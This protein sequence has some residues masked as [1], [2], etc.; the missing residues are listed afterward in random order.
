MVKTGTNFLNY[1][2][3]TQQLAGVVV[4]QPHQ[5]TTYHLGSREWPS[6]QTRF[7]RHPLQ[8]EC[9]NWCPS[10]SITPGAGTVWVYI[11]SRTALLVDP[12]LCKL[13]GVAANTTTTDSTGVVSTFL[14]D[15]MVN[16]STRNSVFFMLTPSPLLSIPAFHALGLE[17]H[18]SWAPA[19][20]TRS[21][22]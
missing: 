8:S 7:R 18:T 9:C 20:S 14:D 13:D 19:M 6:Y 15:I 4:S 22:A 17:I 12:Q 2:Q 11:E 5:S 10:L 21:S 16:I 3:A 1:P